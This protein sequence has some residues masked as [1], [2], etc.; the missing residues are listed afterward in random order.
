MDI[1]LSQAGATTTVV[2]NGQRALEAANSDTFDF[3]LMD[4]QMPEMNGVEA[5]K[6]I[7]QLENKNKNIP[8]VA[9]TANVLI[10]DRTSYL[11]A[12]MNYVLVKPVDEDKLISTILASIH[13]THRRTASKQNQLDSRQT[14]SR[15]TEKPLPTQKAYINLE[16]YKNDLNRTKQELNNEMYAMLLKELP[17]FREVINKAFEDNDFESMDHHVHK[18]H[19]AASFCQ[20]PS[21][22]KSVEALEISIKKKYHRDNIKANLKVVNLEID[23]MLDSVSNTH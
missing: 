7:R 3:I 6:R 9:L 23:T 13:P 4:I 11:L 15:Q 1:L 17:R 2:E 5:T 16:R 12:G 19:G 8:I 14:K 18:L 21:L 22:K 20:A 10:E